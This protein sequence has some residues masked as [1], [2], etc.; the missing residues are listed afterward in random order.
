MLTSSNH[1]LP[2]KSELLLPED[3]DS[4]KTPMVYVR[5]TKAIT[6]T[7][8]SL[9]PIENSLPFHCRGFFDTLYFIS[10]NNALLLLGHFFLQN[11]FVEK[12]II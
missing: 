3:S 9:P 8:T 4:L 6:L 10:W 11:S 7:R 2:T 1:F 5:I 12:K